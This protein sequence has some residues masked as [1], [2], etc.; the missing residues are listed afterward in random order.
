MSH[1]WSR[2]ARP[3]LLLL[4][5][6]AGGRLQAAP[7]PQPAAGP[8]AT[9]RVS[10]DR[11]GIT[12]TQLTGY[13]DVA[14]G[15]K[16]S[17][18]DPVRIA[19]ISKLVATIGVMRLVEQGKL[20]LDADVSPLLG[21]TLRHPKAPQT[22]ITL[23]L[24]LS[25]RAG[26]TD[27]AGYWQ[28]K[29]GEQFRNL[30]ADP[31]AWDEAHVPGTYWRYANID[32]PLIAAVMERATRER[33]D[34]LMDRLV[35]KPLNLAACYN[36]ASCDDAT[37]A[38]A[39]VLYDAGKPV[40]DDNH[41]AK[42]ACPVTAAAD[43]N[44]DLTGW[45][46]GENGGLFSPQGGL[47][48]SINGLAK[49]GRLLLNEGTVD[50][51]TLLTPQSVRTMIEPLWTYAPGNGLTYEEDENT[52]APSKGFTCRYGLA[53]QTLATPHANCGDDPFGDGI[54]RVGHSGDAY[55]M[56]AGVWVD[57]VRG[58]GVAYFA[59]GMTDAPPGTHSAF[60]AIEES[61]ARGQ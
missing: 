42:P 47:R 4:C 31:K 37:A 9:A 28:V 56:L 33:F 16:L 20:D 45:R 48:I 50:G 14:T 8:V 29:L 7:A 12:S 25:H 41:G 52:V 2:T 23:R 59:T 18:D 32:F 3:A 27:H 40:R 61:L 44:C 21:W 15:R 57:R 35:L 54:A 24:L 13:A 34:Q 60:S 53:V 1:A 11:N 10:F 39:V 26:L 58:S 55:G 30:L 51:T 46:A 5:L 38:R 22:P 43:G 49:I 19:S 6:A 36:W 17:A